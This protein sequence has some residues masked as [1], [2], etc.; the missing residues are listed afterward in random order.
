MKKKKRSKHKASKLTCRQAPEPT[1][2]IRLAASASLA[3]AS[4]ATTS[5]AIH[6]KRKRKREKRERETV[7]I[8]IE[9]CVLLSPCAAS[10]SSL[11]HPIFFTHTRVSWYSIE[12]LSLL[13]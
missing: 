13:S 7:H 2:F 11:F 6:E 5:R 10:S 12:F 3:A 9:G 4:E 8:S 1:N